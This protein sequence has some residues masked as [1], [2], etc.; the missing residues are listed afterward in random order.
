VTETADRV[1]VQF[2]HNGPEHGIGR[3]SPRTGDFPWSTAPS[4]RRKFLRSPG[5]VR[6]TAWGDDTTTDVVFWGE[7]EA[8]STYR[9]LSTPWYDKTL[10]TFVHEPYLPAYEPSGW[11]QN[12]DPLV[13]GNRFAYTNCKQQQQSGRLTHLHRL[14]VGSL[15]LFG[16]PLKNPARFILDTVFVIGDADQHP[17][18]AA[19]HPYGDDLLT[20]VAYRPVAN[21]S[22]DWPFT[23]Y[24]G[25]GP[26]ETGEPFSFAP[27]LPADAEDPWF[28]RPVLEPQGVLAPYLV[29]AKPMG[30][31]I[32]PATR[33]QVRA[34][35]EEVVSQVVDRDGRAMATHF[36]DPPRRSVA[37][38]R[39][40]A[41]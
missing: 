21:G 19:R 20:D 40:R 30:Q 23:T 3:R 16:S 28:A 17:D 8:D 22:K 11:R 10:P 36:P 7:W 9:R 12:T 38:Q 34:A 35:W 39:P 6:A 14:P 25:I 24:V 4:H 27:C 33:D 15:I 13:F 1:I 26:T 18:A 29:S 41:R 5:T 2:I 31:I 37:S 32:R